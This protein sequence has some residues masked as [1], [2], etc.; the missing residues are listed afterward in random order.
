MQDKMFDLRMKIEKYEMILREIASASEQANPKHLIDRAKMTLSFYAEEDKEPTT[1]D[2]FNVPVI[3]GDKDTD[4]LLE[5]ER[6]AQDENLKSQ[7]EMLDRHRD[8]E[9]Q[10][11]EYDKKQSEEAESAWRDTV[12]HPDYKSEYEEEE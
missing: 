2:E 3:T 10:L 8:M 7:Q 9:A 4:A 5:D 11:A 6:I 1:A 12:L